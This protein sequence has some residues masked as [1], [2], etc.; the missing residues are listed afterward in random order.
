MFEFQPDCEN[1]E[2]KTI[3]CIS[4][5]QVPTRHWILCAAGFKRVL[6]LNLDSTLLNDDGKLAI[7]TSNNIIVDDLAKRWQMTT[8]PGVHPPLYHRDEL[9]GHFL[10]GQD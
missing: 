2:W 7:M 8:C 3:G 9:L 4:S 6:A 10:A 1:E 5:F